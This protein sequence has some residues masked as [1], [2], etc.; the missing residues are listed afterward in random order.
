MCSYWYVIG[1]MCFGAGLL[2]AALALF[3]MAV[4]AGWESFGKE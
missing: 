1:G 2:I 3:A 4:S